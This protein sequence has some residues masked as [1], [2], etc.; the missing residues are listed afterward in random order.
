MGRGPLRV[1][2][3]GASTEI[4]GDDWTPSSSTVGPGL[5]VDLML[6][7]E[8][9]LESTYLY[10]TDEGNQGG[11]DID[12]N[13]ATLTLGARREF[14]LVGPI[15]PYVSAGGLY[16]QAELDASG[17]GTA[18][19]DTFGGYAAG[20]VDFGLPLGFFLG[21]GVRYTFLTDVQLGSAEG[22]VDGFGAMLR[23]GWSF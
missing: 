5:E 2:L 12:T 18:D 13:V 20:G 15:T 22:D 8:W 10:T 4:S 16:G 11:I 23:L 14:D 17:V 1:A 21:L 7:E 3:V 19:D 9:G 6:T